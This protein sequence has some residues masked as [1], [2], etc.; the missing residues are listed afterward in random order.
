MPEMK[1]YELVALLLKAK[2]LTSSSLA[3][4]LGRTS[5]QSQIYKYIHG[6]V[7]S[8]QMNTARP[9]AAHLGI[10]VEAMYDDR[11]A[12]RVAAE[13]G[14]VDGVPA[15][16]NVIGEPDPTEGIHRVQVGV[17]SSIKA[18]QTTKLGELMMR[19]PRELDDVFYVELDD[20]AM[21]P[22]FPAGTIIKFD[23]RKPHSFG[24]RVLIRD[25]R[26]GYHF[27]TYAQAAHDAWRG[28]AK[29]DAFLEL[30]PT[31]DGAI[32][33]ATKSGHIVEGD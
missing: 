16:Q 28:I 27:R 1:A 32:V 10:P 12:T 29:S 21:A 13:L 11:L 4:K 14:L 33:V 23:R 18:L 26:G 20:N 25:S 9:I 22:D 5:L 31:R 2:G 3:R 24:S 7:P 8:P 6:Q 19:E 15:T 30:E 17:N